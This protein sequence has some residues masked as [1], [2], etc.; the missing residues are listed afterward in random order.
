MFFA[1]L[2]SV[3][4]GLALAAVI[5]VANYFRKVVKEFKESN[6]KFHDEFNELKE[7]QRNQIKAQ[8]VSIYNNAL[9]RGFITHME[10]ETANR[11]ADSYFVLGGNNYIHAVMDNL[12]KMTVRGEPIPDPTIGVKYGD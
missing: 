12:N 7:S 1:I 4:S 6:K 2:T 8:I 11:L 3:L 9:A 5:G 10:L